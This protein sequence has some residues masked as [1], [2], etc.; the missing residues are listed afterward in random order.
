MSSTEKT[1]TIPP[2]TDEQHTAIAEGLTLRIAYC[3]QCIVALEKMGSGKTPLADY[4]RRQQAAAEA[5]R[6]LA[7]SAA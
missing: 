6:E 3:K 4:W 2:V 7:Q 1:R 5:A